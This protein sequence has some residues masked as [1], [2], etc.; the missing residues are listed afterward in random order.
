MNIFETILLFFAGFLVGMLLRKSV[1]LLRAARDS[2]TERRTIQD[3][4]TF[5]APFW[6]MFVPV[7]S[8]SH[9][10]H[11]EDILLREWGNLDYVVPTASGYFIYVG[12]DDENWDE[13]PKN[14]QELC[15]WAFKRNYPW[16]RLDR[17]GCEILDLPRYQW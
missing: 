1:N 13:Y 17:D 8:M 5:P 4:D 10:K 14:L 3:V 11:Y 12:E 16:I 2:S 6:V 15:R 9:I 7:I